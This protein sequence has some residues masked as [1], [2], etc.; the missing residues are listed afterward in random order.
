MLTANV[1]G[2]Y[3]FIRTGGPFSSGCI[4]RPG[5][6]IVHAAIHPM[7]PLARGFDLVDRHLREIGRPIAALS[8]MHLRIPAALSPQGFEEFNRPY[9]ER[10]KAWGLEADGANPVAR[11]NVALEFDPV[12]EPM[13]AGFFYT[14]PSDNDLPT[15]VLSGVPEFAVDAAGKRMIV[16]RGDT[17]ADGIC[18]KLACVMDVLAGHLAMMEL[19]WEH[20]TTINLYT[21]YDVYPA[22]A[23]ALLPALGARARVGLTWHYSRPP[24]T[25]LEVEI[26]AY[27]V[28]HAIV[29]KGV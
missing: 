19:G 27:G 6:E 11:T 17:S 2:N 22:L 15:F 16:A 21:V 29:L 10:L 7:I 13:L 14:A 1:P 9:V 24:V 20:A 18:K 23:E 3:D 26:D 25:G 4:A 8:G 12:G 5:F 28:R